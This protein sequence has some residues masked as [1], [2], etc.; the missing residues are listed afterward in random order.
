MIIFERLKKNRLVN[1]DNI[2]NMQI[3]TIEIPPK[4]KVVHLK[5]YGFIK[6]FIEKLRIGLSCRLEAE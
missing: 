5:A 2:K 3:Q 4:G 6:V 1:P